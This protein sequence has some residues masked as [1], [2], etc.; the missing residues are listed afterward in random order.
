MKIAVELRPNPQDPKCYSYLVVRRCN[1]EANFYNREILQKVREV[2][3]VRV[4]VLC[5][6]Q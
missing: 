2:A 3:T 6:W 1:F 4:G 5:L